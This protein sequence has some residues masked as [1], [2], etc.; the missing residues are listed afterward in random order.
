MEANSC[1]ERVVYAFLVQ[2]T[3]D[4]QLPCMPSPPIH[5]HPQPAIHVDGVNGGW[6]QPRLRPNQPQRLPIRTATEILARCYAK[7][8]NNARSLQS[9]AQRADGAAIKMV[10]ERSCCMC[11]PATLG[12]FMCMGKG[13]K[14]ATRNCYCALSKSYIIIK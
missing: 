9:H 8:V 14:R 7:W 6:P 2:P 4:R 11:R 5:T 1:S 10:G 13:R 3:L 12:A